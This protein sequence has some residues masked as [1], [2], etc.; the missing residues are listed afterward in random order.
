MPLLERDD[1][2]IFLADPSGMLRDRAK[3]VPGAR[4]DNRA[5][6]W[7]FPLSWASCVVARGVF[8]AA[9]EIG[10]EL[11]SWATE[12]RSRRIDPSLQ[13]RSESLQE[14]DRKGP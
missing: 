8:G 7:R 4:H 9:L 14:L 12:E 13:A 2:T 11:A 5:R 10:P 1:D 6:G 3:Q